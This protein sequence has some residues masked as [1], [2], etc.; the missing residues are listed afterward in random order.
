M[1]PETKILIADDEPMN[2]QVVGQ[3]LKRE[4]LEFIFA[5][6]GSEAVE[7]AKEYLPSLILMDVMMP[8]M[9]GIEACV[10]IKKDPDTADIP[11]IFL[12]A[13]SQSE[14]IVEGLAA[15]G[16]DY[17]TKPFQREEL[18]SR[19]RTHL[20]LHEANQR[21]NVLIQ[22]KR[23][24]ISTLAHDVKNPSG[25]IEKLAEMLIDDLESG[26][27]QPK[28]F[29]TC[30]N[31]IRSS[32]SRL[33]TLVNETLDEEKNE[34]DAVIADQVKP[35]DVGEAAREIVDLN[36]VIASDKSIQIRFKSE[37]EIQGSI[38]QRI[39]SE[40][41][42]NLINNAVKY[43]HPDPTSGW[44]C[45]ARTSSPQA[46][47][48]K[49]T[50]RPSRSHPHRPVHSSPNTLKALQP[51]PVARPPRHL[52]ASVQPSCKDSS[53]CSEER[54]AYQIDTI[55]GATNSSSRF[56]PSDRPTDD[57]SLESRPQNGRDAPVP[58]HMV[59]DRIS[60]LL[61]RGH[62]RWASPPDDHAT[63]RL[64]HPDPHYR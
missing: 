42:D 11:I 20:E 38:S 40:V 6:S 29:T 34:F 46:F 31:L 49:S 55:D 8:G 59:P 26:G 50:T 25:A 45:F 54:S 17:I 21:L 48:S 18:L 23:D 60:R 27:V 39:L 62:R 36:Q 4:G 7:T 57:R 47:D 9:S 5:A 22:R 32:A 24:L 33:R 16:V 43:R 12:T 13:K 51:H 37:P 56:P 58:P 3:I 35:V 1:T 61:D 44:S 10:Q 41:F 30:L 28:E 19:I 52:T 14:D 64:R 15:G 2:L 53:R 63:Q